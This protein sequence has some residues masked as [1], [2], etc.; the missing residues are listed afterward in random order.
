MDVNF[1]RVKS[2]TSQVCEFRKEAGC[3]HDFNKLEIVATDENGISVCINLF[4]AGDVAPAIYQKT[5]E[6]AQA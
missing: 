1:H 5:V 4:M 6:V 2:I 3:S